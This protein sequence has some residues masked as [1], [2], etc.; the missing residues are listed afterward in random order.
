MRHPGTKI[1]ACAALLLACVVPAYAHTDNAT[2]LSATP[3]Y[4]ESGPPRL[5]CRPVAGSNGD[6]DTDQP[7]GNVENCRPVTQK[8]AID[9]YDVRYRLN[10]RDYHTFMSHD[11]GR[12]LAVE[13]DDSGNPR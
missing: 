13:V 9:G 8:P 1:A 10:G 7:E 6:P 12:Q 4:H 2:V 11:P 5:D 3:V